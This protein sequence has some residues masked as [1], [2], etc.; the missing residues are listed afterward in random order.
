MSHSGYDDRKCGFNHH[1][2]H[3]LS[4][5]LDRI[6]KAHDVIQI[7][8]KDGIPYVMK[9]QHLVLTNITLMGTEG[10][11]MIV[12]EFSV[13]GSCLFADAA[14]GLSTSRYQVSINLVNLKLI[15]IGI[16]KLRNT[17]TTLNVQVFNCTVSKLSKS[18]IVDSSAKKTIVIL[19]KS[20][21]SQVSKGL[22]V[23]SRE[24]RLSIESS[25]IN[26]LGRY[27]PKRDCPQF[28]V[29]HKFES[30]VACFRKSSFKYTF[31]IDLGVSNQ[32]K[33]NVSIID[34]VFDD[35]N[36]N[37]KQNGC[38]PGITLR[39]TAALI[40][41]SSFTNIIS[42]NSL[43]KAIASFVTFKECIFSNISSK[44]GMF[45]L[46][47]S[48]IRSFKKTNAI[49]NKV[50]GFNHGSVYLHSTECILLNCTFHNNT[51]TGQ[52]GSGGALY[53]SNSNITVQ[54]SLFN[55]NTA[56]YSGSAIEMRKTRG[57]LIN[58]TFERNSAKLLPE[59]MGFGRGGAI[60]SG[61]GS[62]I[63][64]QQS[65]FKENTATYSG[66]AIHMQKTRGSFFNCTF[67]RNSA[68]RLPEKMGSGRGGAIFSGLVS[69]I[70]V[71]QSLF[72]EN[73]ATYNGGAIH[74]QKTRGSFFNCTFERNSAKR[75][76]EKMGSG[77]GGAIFSG[78]GSNTTVQ[79]SLFKE[80]TV[81]Y[82]GGAIHMEQTRGSFVNCTFK[83]NSAKS[84][85]EKMRSG[86]GGVIS[87]SLGSNVTVQ[88]S[89]F[90]ENTATYSGGAI[91]VQKTRGSFVNCTFERNSVKSLLNKKTFGGA[92]SSALGSNITVQQSLFKENTA[93]YSGGA[94]DMQKTRGSFVNCTFE[95]NSAKS[96]L[97]KKAF[98]GAISSGLG[99]NITVKQRL[100]KENTATFS[101]GSI[102]MQKTRG[103]FV[104]CT[105][106]RNT[107]KGLPDK[108]SFGG[109]ICSRDRSNI[110]VQQSLFKENTVIYSGGAI[111]MQK[112]RG[113][114]V[115]CTFERNSAKSLANKMAIGGAISSALGSNITVQQSL[116]KENTAI[117]S[118][119]AID[120]QKTRGSFVN[121]TFERNS[122][123]CLPD[124]SSFGGAICSSDRSNIAVQQSF[125]KENTATYSGGAIDMQK[126][127]GSL[128]NCTF[129]RNSAKSLLNKKTFGGAIS[130][131]LGSNITVKQSLFKEN[132]AT[133]IGGAID[134][135]K[136]RGSFVNCTFER[137]SA[138]RLLNKKT[139][140][141]A[142]SSRDRSNIAVQQ[143][144][145]K[146]N[147]AT[148]SGGA[149][150]MQ[151]TRGSF[152]TCTFERNTLKGLSDKSSFGGAICL[153]DRS[154][155]A[156]QQSLFKE[157]TAT[158]SGGAIHMQKTGGSFVNCTFERNSAKSL[159]NKKTFGGA[160]CSGSR[161]NIAV[162]Q[163]LF[164]ENTATYSGGAID[165][166]KTRG[167]FVNCT[168]ERNTLKG[169]P[170][171]SS[172]GGAI[173]LRDRSNIAVQQS[174]FKE[175]TA[176]YSG[177]AIDMQKTR[178]S[179][180]TCTFERNTLKGLSDKSSF[181][182]AICLRDRS[183]IAVQQSLF[184]ENT[185]TYSGGAIHMQKTGGSFVNC[186]FERNSAKSLLNKKTFGG[187]ICSRDRSNIAVQ[188]SLFKEN[189]A[190]YSGG[191]IDMQKT[192]GSFVNCTFERNTLKG[193]P[194][195]SSFGGAICLRDMSNMAVQQSLF[196]ENTA[197]YSGGAIH[198]QKTRGSF[199]NCT[200]ERN[201][202]KSL[203]NKKT[204]DGAICS[205]DRS[206]I[207]V[208]QS[209]FKENTATY[210]G[211]AIDMQKTR[212]SFV[213]CTFE[214]NTLKGLQ[215]KS[216][217]GG[218]ICSCDRS[219]ITVQQ[220]LFKENTVTYSGGAIHMQKTRGSFV[221]CTFERNSAKS[222]TKKMGIGGAIS[223]ALGSNITV[224]QSLFKE[225][226]AILSG[227]AID[228]QKT[229]GSFVN[230]TFERNTLKGLPEKSSFGGA[231][232]L[233]DRSN[234]AVQQSLFKENTATYSGGAIDMQKTR[235]SFVNCT[236]ERNSAKSLLNKKTFGGAI[237]SG[238]RSNIAVQ[239]SL[240]KENT[241]TYSG[242]A[243]DMQKTRGSFV[244]CTF[245]RNSAKSLLNKKTF[246]GA[247]CSCSRSNIAVQQSL[248]KENTA[249]YRGGAIHMQ[250][251]RG[252]FV[253]CTF[254]RNSAKCLLNKETF[255]GAICSHLGSN[256]TVQQSLFNENTATYTGGAIDM[257]K[258]RGSFVNCTF[259]RN[260]LKG[261]PDKSSFGGAICSYNRSN[262]AV[263]QSLFKENTVTYSGGATFIQCSQ[264]SFENCTFKGK[265]WKLCP[266]N[267][268]LDG[269]SDVL[270]TS[271]PRMHS[272]SLKNIFT[273]NWRNI[274][275]VDL[276]MGIIHFT[277]SLCF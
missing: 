58:C 250:K 155:I 71:Q 187:A 97:N 135:Q 3:T 78:L 145:F 66:G 49:H 259:E 38:F 266:Q 9:K 42:R 255:G 1:P 126:T 224:Q 139:F 90:K 138:K 157:N 4:Y 174:L 159:L 120:M 96:L 170:D 191:A 173:C 177:G 221:N 45:S 188:Q 263:Q 136:T 85:P 276:R 69:N 62:N 124:K 86:R 178:G 169:L 92:I 57:S 222:L 12:G 200:F 165:M 264:S 195:K 133:F 74:M 237:C 95:R 202:A 216:S 10:R 267:C 18:S 171:K 212:G 258:T 148:Y 75:L 261:L 46:S 277:L 113:S 127:R 36:E 103:S 6:A 15:R 156:V 198:M 118:G 247:I 206:N 51:V 260:T 93:T 229:R 106:E 123:K 37:F 220:S 209:L 243:I 182:G 234:I 68:K 65:L 81:T 207:A 17:L 100:F 225:N 52:Y 245:E 56:T 254:E 185:A 64:A 268:K 121:C 183:N 94:I 251:T 122:L 101:G 77:L 82:S 228:M 79:Q 269:A 107:L 129:E 83:R 164:K 61:L 252:S 193:L 161:S 235:G 223:S 54:H 219:N 110:M 28:I 272:V 16:I 226:T 8:G 29:T 128:L 213:N 162:Q 30:F 242:G 270:S 40:V 70:T 72:K 27:Y 31:L 80:N 265:V 24:V 44:L 194:D 60:S 199:V 134:M 22:Q 99:S 84:L 13:V 50:N 190:T 146:E 143:S 196:K 256:I 275:N 98:G 47:S 41:N 140:I 217:F 125:F 89:L 179:F 163:S 20:S 204:F 227:G 114:F 76:P 35:D 214:R 236:F 180:V 175:N 11:A 39:N 63:T 208:Q 5:T 203:L 23:K 181:G 2:C 115:N 273:L 192:R 176:T 112:T 239:Q 25:K 233:C 48:I 274:Y 91:D 186:T 117:L 73:T 55:G 102:D 167:S 201:S 130:S 87:S 141:G 59:K 246:G 249:T 166:Q 210:S 104:N 168:F 241:A 231:I 26:N 88:Q 244:N 109:A 197:I 111:H 67:E 43:I 160:I 205:R 271:Y 34:C 142:I 33:S 119:G 149:I 248:F 19:K 14:R 154:N 218:A 158:Y 108:S 151:K 240:F 116:F 152:V 132:T 253:N 137:N 211:G 257:K 238:S 172:F 230:C 32:K 150:D 147:T 153:R 144:L 131:G 262:I 189:T 105:F 21:F 53:I 232:S 7:N 184:K 215:D